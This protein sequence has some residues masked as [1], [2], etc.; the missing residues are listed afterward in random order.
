MIKHYVVNGLSNDFL[1]VVPGGCKKHNFWN[2]LVHPLKNY[3]SGILRL[4]P[5]DWYMHGTDPRRGGGGWL[6][7]GSTFWDTPSRIF[8]G[9]F[10]RILKTPLNS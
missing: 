1:I 7:G 8:L 10:Y 2:T 6:R 4:K 5:I 3:I 9:H